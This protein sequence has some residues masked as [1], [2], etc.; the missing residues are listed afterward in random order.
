MNEDYSIILEDVTFTYEGSKKP[1]IKNVN[2]KIKR[3]EIVSILGK[4]GAGKS[5]LIYIIGGIIPN[6]IHGDLSGDVIIEGLNTREYSLYEIAQHVGVVM[7][8]PEAHIVSSTVWEDVAFGPCNLGLPRDEVYER[9]MFALEAT[10]LTELKERNPYNLSG[11]EKQSL[12]IAG[13]LAMRPKILALD[14]PT[15]MLDPL[16]RRRVYEV[17]KDLNR[18]FGITIILSGHDIEVIVG[19]ADRIVVMN[20]GELILDGPLSKVLQ[21]TESLRKAGVRLPEVTR[22]MA[23]L[24]EKGVW[25]GSLPMTLEEAYNYLAKV[26]T[27]K[28]VLFKPYQ[29]KKEKLV[30]PTATEPIIKIRRLRHTY[31]NGVEA[32]KGI[33]LDIYPGEYV[34]FIGQNGSGKTTLARHI[35]GLLKP[36]NKEAE[37]LVAGLDIRKAKMREIVRKVGYVFQIP[38]HQIFHSIT[39]EEIEFGLKNLEFPKNEIDRKVNEILKMLGLE[40]FKEEWPLSLDRGKRFRIALGSILAIDPEVIIVDEPTTGQDWRESLYI[41]KILKKLN[42]R[43]KTVVIITHEMDLVAAFATRV[44]VLC[45]G[46]ILLDGTPREVFSKPEI[47]EKTWVQPPQITRLSHKLSKLCA[48]P[49]ML[50]VD[51]MYDYLVENLKE[52]EMTWF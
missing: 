2:L 7:D 47:L 39:R 34:A 31:P 18:K 46:R 29:P 38:E 35:A 13:V 50:T 25:K 40:E 3:G 21:E 12:A 1:T 32:L 20:E 48:I 33:D 42:Q 24:K 19:L 16:G 5:T 41:C 23:L 28:K 6:Y 22:L 9:M 37:I 43:G 52:V 26:F 30:K 4:T 8:D 36:T 10:R 27:R 17:L 14:E 44:I 11:G 45:K 49:T 15:S 51:E